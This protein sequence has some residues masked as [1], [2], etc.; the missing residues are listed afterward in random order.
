MFVELD[1]ATIVHNGHEEVV[2]K[3][4]LFPD[5]TRWVDD[6]PEVQVI[7]KL[8]IDTTKIE[9]VTKERLVAALYT[10][11]GQYHCISHESYDK[12]KVALATLRNL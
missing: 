1:T 5:I 6:V 10:T 9:G 11:S 8:L 3:Q 7:G 12:L 2:R 4:R